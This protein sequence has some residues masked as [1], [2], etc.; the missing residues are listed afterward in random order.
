M[1]NTDKLVAQP[2]DDITEFLIWKNT[3]K[4]SDNILNISKEISKNLPK[5]FVK[6]KIK[7]VE[8]EKKSFSKL[9]NVI[10]SKFGIFQNLENPENLE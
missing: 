1:V 3:N 5:D 8:N 7:K 9:L 4:L 10:K 6:T 2:I